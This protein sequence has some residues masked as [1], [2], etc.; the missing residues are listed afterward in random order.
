MS[1]RKKTTLYRTL[2][3]EINNQNY[4]GVVLDMGYFS[5]STV[6]YR[7]SLLEFFE[8]LSDS[9]HAANKLLFYVVPDHRGSGRQLFEAKDLKELSK[10]VDRFSLMTY[11]FSVGTETPRN[12]A[13][14]P[15]WWVVH[16]MRSLLLHNEK[17]LSHKLLVG[18]NFYG[19]QYTIQDKDSSLTEPAAILGPQFLKLIASPTDIKSNRKM[20]W[21]SANH[22]NYLSFKTKKGISH[23]VYYPTLKS[24]Q[25]RLEKIEQLGCGV[26]IWEIGQGLSYFYELL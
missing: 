10:F 9:L 5:F 19:Y 15:L 12:G 22:E 23:I 14:S 20:N 16:N 4:D 8:K 21:D 1:S 18:L 6:P 7:K 25:A 24:I 13:I 26:S 11:D 17:S 3:K 2:V